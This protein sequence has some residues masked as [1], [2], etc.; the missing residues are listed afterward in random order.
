MNHFVMD[1]GDDEA[2]SIEDKARTLREE[3]NSLELKNTLL[4][5][6]VERMTFPGGDKAKTHRKWIMEMLISMPASKGGMSGR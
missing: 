3:Q 6:H 4:Q 1:G 2:W 5:E